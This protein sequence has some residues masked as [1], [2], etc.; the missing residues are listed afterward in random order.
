MKLFVLLFILVSTVIFLIQNQQPIVLYFLGTNPQTAL[1][2]WKLP[3]GIWVVL[4][5]SAGILTSLIIQWLNQSSQSSA[6]KTFMPPPRREPLNPSEQRPQPSDSP[7]SSREADWG[8]MPQRNWQGME[9]E[10]T[11]EGDDWDIEKPPTERTFPR[12]ELERQ[13]QEDEA[14]NFEVQQP[15]KKASRQGSVY[16]YT[17]RELREFEDSPPPQD[18]VQP[19]PKK[20]GTPRSKSNTG[21]QVYDANYRILTPPY[22]NSQESSTFD[23]S[24]DKDWV[25]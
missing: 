2:T 13:L 18:S 17:Y 6:S 23:D 11:E 19:P 16:S 14:I 9:Q 25:E 12:E 1:F 21:D 20:P 3:I 7:T 22:R 5:S 8:A 10:S 4:F 24:E 15:P